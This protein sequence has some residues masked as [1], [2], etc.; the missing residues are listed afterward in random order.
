MVL[1]ISSIIIISLFITTVI[2]GADNGD[3][4]QER[5]TVK[6]KMVEATKVINT[7]QPFK[8]VKPL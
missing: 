1:L 2:I 8:N 3:S 5:T 7:K 6:T 4:Y